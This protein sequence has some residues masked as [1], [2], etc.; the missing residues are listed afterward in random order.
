VT[1][2]TGS[3]LGPYEILAAIGAGGMGEVYRAR[4]PR[5]SREVAIKVLPASFSADPDRLRRFEQEAKAAGVLNHP[6]I[7]AVYDIGTNSVDGAPY[8]VQELLEGETLRAVLA[9]GRLP[10]RK[11]VDYALQIAHGLAAAHDKGIVHRDL[12]PE[13][14]FVTHAGRVKILDFG[15]AKLVQVTEGSGAQTNLPTAAGTEP[16]VVMGTLGYMSPEQIKGRPAD[17]R[18]DLFSFGAIFYEMLSGKRAFHAD[19]AGET[20]AAI[21]KEDPPDLSVTNQNVSPGLERIVRHCLEKNPEQRFHSAHDLA[22]D[23]EALSGTSGQA[24]PSAALSRSRVRWLPIAL[25]ALGALAGGALALLLS[26]GRALPAASSTGATFRRLTNLSGGEGSPSLSPDG[27]TLA[28]VH[29]IDNRVHVWAQR[30]SGHKPI[31]LTPDCDLASYSPSFSPDGSLIAYGSRC[32][33]GGLFFMGASGESVRRLTSFGAE[34]DWS[35]DGKELVF[36]TE[37][38]VSPYGRMGTSEL[39]VVSLAGGEPRRLYSEDAIQPSVS[40]HGLRIAFWALPLGGSQRDIWTIPAKGLSTG[41]K[42]VP[43]TQDQAMDWYPVWAPDG[44]SLYFLSNR[45]GAMNLW[46]VPIDEASGK[47]LGPPVPE[48]LPAREVGGFALSR[49]GRS[50]A[51]VDRETTFAFDRLQFDAAG[52]LVGNPVEISSSSQEMSDFDVSPDQTLF[53][54]DTR[55]AAQD[56]LFVVRS[57][58]KG[59]RQLTD[60]VYRD[61][62]PVF[63]PDGK[64]LAFHSDRSG[65]YEIWTVA[66]D[67]SDLRQLTKTTGDTTIEPLW[68]PDGRFI[69][70]N[71]GKVCSVLELDGKGA[72]AK[73]RAVSQADPHTAV[74]PLGWSADGRRLVC[75][76]VRLPDRVT[77]GLA[78][79]SPDTNTLSE[80][81]G[82]RTAGAARRGGFLG[83]R[84]IFVDADGIRVADLAAGTER[85]AVPYGDVARYSYVTCRG[86]ICYAARMSDNSD[87]WLRTTPETAHP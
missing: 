72:V 80:S 21:L 9:A 10:Q 26:R 23:I 32:G 47:T 65:R 77:F 76:L 84:A 57:D 71:T 56:D 81:R 28:F 69:A 60:D 3:K 85:L 54:F 11:V 38:V 27:Q 24:V 30:V 5:L 31:D 42:P 67:G 82:I 2:A 86:T 36:S 44:R 8:V 41:E 34:P 18:S 53:A 61:R 78:N 14:L 70:T 29:R 62:H 35:A 52:R 39:W 25:L 37:P 46:R 7:T 33:E 51:Y 1:L 50:V 15:L 4:D 58:G 63:S 43:V 13:N 55:G 16:G 40:P 48:R 59:L 20:M 6:N 64:R 17:A 75:A 49:D 73:T 22:F 87:I 68:S 19:S 74:Y 79:Y 83:D 12:K 66:T 45:D